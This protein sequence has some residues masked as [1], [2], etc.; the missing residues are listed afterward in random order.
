M[1]SSDKRLNETCLPYSGTMN[2]YSSKY[3]P[4]LAPDTSATKSKYSGQ[5]MA[6]GTTVNPINV[7]LSPAKIPTNIT[8]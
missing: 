4:L 5:A 8:A 6:E 1:E 7:S 2:L 3:A